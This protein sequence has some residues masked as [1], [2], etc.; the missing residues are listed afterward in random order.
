[1][2]D[3]PEALQHAQVWMDEVQGVEAVGECEF[4]GEPCISVYISLP[5]AAARLPSEFQGFKVVIEHGG[6][7]QAQE[8]D[9]RR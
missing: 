2:V 3:F 6:P 9:T 1:M 4:E 5:E 7:F 8:T